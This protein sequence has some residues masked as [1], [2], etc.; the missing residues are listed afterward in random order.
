[1]SNKAEDYIHTGPRNNWY[2]GEYKPDLTRCR[3]SVAEYGRVT[4]WHQCTRKPVENVEGYGF[5]KIHSDEVKTKLG[6]RN[7][8]T[9]TKYAAAFYYGK[10][11]L[12]ELKIFGE[13][14]KT[15]DIE[16]VNE[17][18]G[19][20]FGLYKGKSKKN[21]QYTAKYEFFDDFNMAIS[22]LYTESESHVQTT[23]LAYEAAIQVRNKLEAEFLEL[24]PKE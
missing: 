10:P 12:V 1:M 9:K 22:Y 7:D 6:I 13:T 20:A 17:L 23:L 14:E 4:D 2:K 8:S 16:S 15:I 3:Y 24:A 21:S 11:I 19:S 5:C 18:M